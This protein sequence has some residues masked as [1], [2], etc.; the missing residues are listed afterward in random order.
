VLRKSTLKQFFFRL[1]DKSPEI[2]TTVFRKLIAEK[3]SIH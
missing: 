2:R 1:R 3:I